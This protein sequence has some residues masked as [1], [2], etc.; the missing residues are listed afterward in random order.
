LGCDPLQIMAETLYIIDGHAQMYRAYYAPFRDL[1]SPAGEPTRATYVFCSMLMK[2]IA[3]RRPAMLAMAIDGPTSSRTRAA[4]YPQYKATRKPMPE[5]FPVQIGR[6]VGI[7]RAMGIPVLQADG[8]EADDIIATIAHRYASADRQVVIISRDKDLD[9]L[10]S[11]NVVLYDPM[12][13]E[14]IDAATILAQKGFPPQQAVEVQ[15]LMGD[16]IDN[17][18]GIPGI[19]PKTAAKL[20]M[21]YGSADAVV[22]HAAE[23]TPKLRDNIIQHAGNV[24]LARQLVTLE[25]NLPMEFDVEQMRFAGLRRG[26]LRSV[27]TE[28][29]FNRLYDQLDKARYVADE[30]ALSSAGSTGLATPARPSMP[31]AQNPQAGNQSAQ[32]DKSPTRAGRRKATIGGLFDSPAAQL[33]GDAGLSEPPGAESIS[34]QASAWPTTNSTEGMTTAADF[35]YRCIDTIEALESVAKELSVWSAAGSGR[36]A[37]DTETTGTEPMWCEIVGMSLAWKTGSAIYIPVKNSL[38]DPTVKLE[39]VR[40]LIGPIVADEKI[41]KVGHNLKYDLIVLANAGMELRGKFFDTMVAAHVL[42]SMRLSYALSVL[43]AEILKHNCLRIAELIG[44]GKKQITMDFVPCQRVASHACEDVD[45]ALRLA[46]LFDAQLR[47]AG[48]SKLFEELEMPLLPVLAEME[49][50]GIIVDSGVLERM[51]KELSAQ[52]SLLS[53]RIILSAGRPFNIDSPKQLAKVLFEDLKL[54]V[55]K[56][57]ATSPSTDSDVLEQLAIMHELPGLV[58]D[59]RKLTKLI[60][61]Y[62]VALRQCIH[63]RTGRVHTDFHQNGTATGRL[64]SSDPNL[65]NIPIRS[66]E[67]KRIRAAFVAGA[68][69]L[70]MSADYSQVELRVLAHLCQDPTLTAAF[71]ADQDIHSIVAAEVFGV[72]LAQVTPEQRSRAKTVNFGIIYGQTAFGLSVGL[73]ISRSEAGE[74]IK[75]YRSRFPKI[76]EFLQSCITF[77]KDNGYVETI[78]GRRRRI[79]EIVAG[80]SQRRAMAER[81]AIN[82]VV[83]GSAADLIK[84][85][86]VNISNRTRREGLAGKMLLQIHD[87][88]VFE[89]PQQDIET[90]RQMVVEEMSQAIQLTVPLKVDVGI[91]KNWMEAK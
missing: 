63:P 76:E 38:G 24:K 84:Q 55:I 8:Y 71:H 67:G 89:V 7:V 73:R 34:P 42:D 79:T 66:E 51:E 74:F 20:V 41:T 37:V 14:T 46:E 32:A 21:Q 70:L 40:R 68:G 9:Q 88:L 64:S 27:F 49:Q 60:G 52:A 5:D 57:T 53:E 86:M 19:G 4:I 50:T 36:L 25:R 10:V 43:S 15:T 61:T 31:A 91:G 69:C 56:R 35:D 22:D 2:F 30:P 47:Q 12:K 29:G 81:L 90:H 82:S 26:V 75:Q 18:P 80:N 33:Q 44:R 13:D 78:F 28:L 72:P 83:Q 59:Y 62:L 45:L 17:V 54:P 3:D 87:E 58:L 39:D 6:I 16:A 1:T 85:A 48:L 23:L 77:A 11:P 65:Q